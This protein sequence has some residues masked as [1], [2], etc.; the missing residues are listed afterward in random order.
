MKVDSR[1]RPAVSAELGAT[2]NVEKGEA[3]KKSS[4]TANKRN[5]QGSYSVR[6]SDAV[7]NKQKAFEDSLRIA[8]NT[9]PTRP[10][11]IQAL[12]EQ[13][14]TGTYNPDAEQ[15]AQGMLREAMREKLAET[16]R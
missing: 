8:Q 6:L 7:K 14:A 2:A 3:A 9:E 16:E 12:K 10:E 13:I 15:I 11:R 5:A 4:Q 1:A